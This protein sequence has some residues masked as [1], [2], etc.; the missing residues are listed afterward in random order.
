MS[1]I[2]PGSCGSDCGEEYMI[3]THDLLQCD[4]DL[5]FALGNRPES[6]P[7]RALDME[8]IEAG[9]GFVP[10]VFVTDVTGQGSWHEICGHWFWNNHFGAT[11]VCQNF[12]FPFG[13][14]EKERWTNHDWTG[15][16]LSTDGLH[17]GSCRPGESL[18]TCSGAHNRY[19]FPGGCVQGETAGIVVICAKEEPPQPT[20]AQECTEAPGDCEELISLVQPGGCASDCTVDFIWPLYG[21]LGCD[22][23][24]LDIRGTEPADESED[25]LQRIPLCLKNCT[26]EPSNCDQTMEM[27]QPGGCARD[28]TMDDL[29]PL[30]V[31]MGCHLSFNSN[32]VS[33]DAKDDL[34]GLRHNKKRSLRKSS[35][36]RETKKEMMQRRLR[37]S[38][39]FRNFSS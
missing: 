10:E 18:E 14:L 2:R 29:E 11:A 7:V 39:P 5:S 13:R 8:T 15:N 27:I 12:G 1:A 20:C 23:D 38:K 6:L 19:D 36:K 4:F 34:P 35:Q 17:I 24:I 33:T 21:E 22:F 9:V 26:T 3:Q 31:S 25:L 37:E 28:C 30:F 32:D 16:V